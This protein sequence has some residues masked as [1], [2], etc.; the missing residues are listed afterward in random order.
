MINAN[1]TG[2]Q[3]ILD[4]ALKNKVKK[5]VITSHMG[6]IIGNNHKREKGKRITYYHEK[7]FAPL[8][9]GHPYIQS[10]II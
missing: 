8:K 3:A 5:V 2:T 7:D 9:I 1:K 6:T 4:A 10:K